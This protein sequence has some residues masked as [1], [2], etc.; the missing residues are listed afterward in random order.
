MKQAL[1]D[2]SHDLFVVS[3]SSWDANQSTKLRWKINILSSLSYLKQGLHSRMYLHLVSSPEVVNHVGSCLFVT[4]VE[5]IFLWVHIPLDLVHF[6]GTMWTVFGHYNCA[7]EFFID[8]IIVVSLA[9]IIN[10]GQAIVYRE[11]L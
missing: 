10:E 4:L 3:N 8:K 7:L 2:V 5:D 1:P 9:S 11:E 6:V